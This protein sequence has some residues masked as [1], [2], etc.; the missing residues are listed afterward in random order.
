LHRWTSGEVCSAVYDI[1]SCSAGAD[2]TPARL[3]TRASFVF[4]DIPGSFVKKQLSALSFQLLTPPFQD[5]ASQTFES[6]V[7]AAA[8]LF[9]LT[10]CFHRHSRIV[11]QKTA[12]STQ[13]SAL[14]AAIPGW[15]IADVRKRRLRRC[16]TF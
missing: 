13:L 15:R 11:R 12:F 3:A 16:M 14:N 2:Y 1:L 4:I 10:L 8:R 5:G 9:D 6:D 7:C